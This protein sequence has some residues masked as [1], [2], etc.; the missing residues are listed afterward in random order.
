MPTRNELVNALNAARAKHS[1]SFDHSSSMTHRH[2]VDLAIWNLRAFD[3]DP[4]NIADVKSAVSAAEAGFADAMRTVLCELRADSANDGR[5]EQ[6]LRTLAFS[7]ARVQ[8]ANVAL[9]A[10]REEQR[11]MLAHEGADMQPQAL[12]E[13]RAR[14]VR[15]GADLRPDRAGALRRLRDAKGRFSAATEAALGEAPGNPEAPGE[16]LIMSRTGFVLDHADVRGAREELDAAR[17]EL[18]ALERG[19]ER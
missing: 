12:E 14:L 17:A 10:R 18:E 4:S 13:L 16:P 7:D 15:E 9:N 19:S 11:A 8:A 2:A 1:A 6:E 5:D 3:D